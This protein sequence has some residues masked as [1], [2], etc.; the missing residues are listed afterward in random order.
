M[1]V[2]DRLLRILRTRILGTAIL[3]LLGCSVFFAVQVERRRRSLQLTEEGD[4]KAGDVVRVVAPI[5]GDEISVEDA[6]GRRTVVRLLGLRTFE[7]SIND[8]AVGP[9]GQRAFEHISQLV[10]RQVAVFP[11]DPARDSRQRLLAYVEDGQV[12]PPL[13]VALEMIRQ[14]LGVAYT[15]FGH[16]REVAYLAAEVEAAR[17]RAGVWADEALVKRIEARKAA[18]QERRRQRP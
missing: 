4:F 12:E 5:D 14:G 2:A 11:G 3:G 15:E 8:P 16:P 9:H 1:K 13:D 6:A 10:G 17:N 18:W 7:P